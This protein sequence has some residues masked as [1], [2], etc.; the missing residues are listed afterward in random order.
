[1]IHGKVFDTF[2]NYNPLRNLSHD[3]E[4]QPFKVEKSYTLLD[5]LKMDNLTENYKDDSKLDFAPLRR[6][7]L[8][9]NILPN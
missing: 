6:L 2:V 1:M 3:K 9:L 4:G 8:C 5:W 7:Q